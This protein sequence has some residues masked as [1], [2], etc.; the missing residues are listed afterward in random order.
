MAEHRR[1]PVNPVAGQPSPASARL[2]VD[3][4]RPSEG[5]LLVR[6]RGS[7]DSQTAA[8]L[9]GRLIEASPTPALRAPRILLD[10][11][12][13]AFLDHAGL[14]TLLHLQERWSTGTVELLAPSPSVVRLLHET[15]LDGES[16]MQEMPDPA[17][18]PRR[19]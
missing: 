9:L 2:I 13:V 10:L 18:G 8:E 14:D 11:S 3:I 17:P 19:T 6:L 16:W 1:Q 4:G 5:V 15:D 7:L 12:G